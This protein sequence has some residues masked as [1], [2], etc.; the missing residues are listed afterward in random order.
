MRMFANL[1][2]CAK[3]DTVFQVTPDFLRQRGIDLLLLDLDNTL[4][5]YYRTDPPPAMGPWLQRMQAG[6]I[7]L[8]LVSNNKK[9]RAVDFAKSI[10]AGCVIMAKK[11][12]TDGIVKALQMAG[13]RPEQAAL[14]GDQIYADVLGANR[15]GVYS[16]LVRPLE[17]KDPR[18]ALRYVAELPFRCRTRKE[19]HG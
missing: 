5:P 8:F 14:A 10:G 7:R 16:I 4:S 3:F 17:L 6:G 9:Q 13:R 19:Q 1:I 11:P 2:P 12:K 18:F 15:A